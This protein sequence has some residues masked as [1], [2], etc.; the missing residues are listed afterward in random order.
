MIVKQVAPLIPILGLISMQ[1][2]AEI[3]VALV[4]LAMD[5][6]Q[7]FVLVVDLEELYTI[8]NAEP[9]VL[10]VCTTQHSYVNSAAKTVHHVLTAVL[11]AH[12][13]Q[14]QLSYTTSNV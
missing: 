10:K 9:N 7:M 4:K 1:E 11:N 8:T 3:A 2:C 14:H 12:R 13:V 5:K 6:L